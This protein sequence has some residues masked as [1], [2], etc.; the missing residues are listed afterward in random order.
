[1]DALSAEFDQLFSTRTG[2]KHLDDRIQK[3][4][5]KKDF[6]LLVLQYPELPLHNSAAELAARVMTR[7]RDVSLHTMT[8]EGTR[9]NDTFLTIVET[10]KK[11]RVNPFEYIYDRVSKKY[12][13]PSLAQLIKQSSKNKQ[14]YLLQPDSGNCCYGSLVHLLR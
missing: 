3:T 9:A 11:L 7:K 8:Q 1:M 6:L 13:L 14:F 4:A 5:A 12:E 10:C 2:Y